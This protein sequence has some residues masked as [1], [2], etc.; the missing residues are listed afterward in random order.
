MMVRDHIHHP[1]LPALTKL[2]HRIDVKP[3]TI[4]R[5]PLQVGARSLET[6]RML[7][8][9]LQTFETWLAANASKIPVES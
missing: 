4:D 3:V 6:S 5:H 8:P 9:K 2:F 1:D 7:N